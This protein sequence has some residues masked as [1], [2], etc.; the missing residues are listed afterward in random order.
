MTRTMRIA[1]LASFGLLFAGN[2]DA[3]SGGWYSLG[4]G[5]PYKCHR[6]H[7]IHGSSSRLRIVIFKGSVD[8]RRCQEQCDS[9]S[10]CVA[11]SFQIRVTEEGLAASV[12][13]LHSRADEEVPVA[14]PGP[15][16]WGASCYRVQPVE[17]YLPSEWRDRLGL[18]Q[19]QLRP[20]LRPSVPAIPNK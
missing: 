16:D 7:L 9:T 14:E 19:N 17:D 5:I 4:S 12:C 10:G 18:H 2:A 8:I 1:G 11:F 6:N 20:D 13:M 3:H 15:F